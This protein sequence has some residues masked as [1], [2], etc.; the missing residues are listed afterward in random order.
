NVE[1]ECLETRLLLSDVS[2]A[3]PVQVSA[4]ADAAHYAKRH[5]GQLQPPP[6]QPLVASAFQPAPS[7][8]WKGETQ[9]QPA[10]QP[11]AGDGNSVVALPNGVTISLS[12]V[13]MV[14]DA[15]GTEST[16]ASALPLPD[17]PLVGVLGRLGSNE[18]LDLYRIPLDSF[19][20]GFQITVKAVAP[21]ATLPG[22]VWLLD[23]SGHLTGDW[24]VPPGTAEM[25]IN[26]SARWRPADSFMVFGVSHGD[27]V[28]D[29]SA[30]PFTYEVIV[31]RFAAEAAQGFVNGNLASFVTITPSSSIGGGS[32]STDSGSSI[33]EPNAPS[34]Q[35][36]LPPPVPTPMP[37]GAGFANT[38]VVN[39]PLP[40]RSAAPSGGVLA[41][42][43]AAPAVD[44]LDAALVDLTLVNIGQQSHAPTVWDEVLLECPVG[45]E[46]GA[47]TPTVVALQG[48]G[49]FPILAAALVA[50][51]RP[52]N[53]STAA[54]MLLPVLG[55]PPPSNGKRATASAT[56]SPATNPGAPVAEA[57]A[58]PGAQKRRP[59]RR[60]VSMGLNAAVIFAFGLLLPDLVAALQSLTTPAPRVRL[61]WP[62]LV[63]QQR[64]NRKTGA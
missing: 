60:S 49:G 48:S 26:L 63:R 39:G 59:S 14:P 55:D 40:T 37:T 45:R 15:T 2:L 54:V 52:G 9:T 57:P 51:M 53:S 11:G 61:R 56:D 35:V 10:D 34:Q 8:P 21:S 43:I 31:A 38:G 1:L 4:G 23:A 47:E 3:F 6:T 25:T 12:Q 28:P 19:S 50:Q 41:D 46:Q 62:R 42:G 20:V 22:R 32:I 64:K 5:Q 24:H 18:G 29:A 7:S 33:P 13:P 17:V 36:A 58:Q 30:P 27:S 44:R 16:I